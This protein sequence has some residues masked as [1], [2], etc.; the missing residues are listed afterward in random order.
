[1]NYSNFLETAVQLVSQTLLRAP[2]LV[3]LAVLAFRG[4]AAGAK[5]Q[6]ITWSLGPDLPHYRKAAVTAVIE[7]QVISACG[8]EHPWA[9]SAETFALP[10]L[11]QGAEWQQLPNCPLGRA[12]VQGTAAGNS[13]YVIGGRRNF[14]AIPDVDKLNRNA[15]GWS[16]S[17]LPD[18]NVPR[19]GA[20]AAFIGSKLYVVGGTTWNGKNNDSLGSVEVL[21]TAAANPAWTV[22][23]QIP[24]SP[25]AWSSVA[26]IN[27]KLYVFG[28]M[29][30][31]KRADGT[32]VRN[33]L[34][35]VKVYD[36]ATN[37]WQNLPPLP[38]PWHGHECAVYQNRY[39]IILGGCCYNYPEEYRE[40]KAA[41]PSNENYYNPFVIVYD[42]QEPGYR[43]LPTPL[44]YPTNNIGAALVGDTVVAIGGENIDPA[45]SNTTKYVRYGAIQVVPEPSASVML[46]AGLVI[47]S[48]VCGTKGK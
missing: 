34:D 29:D 7:G 25:R 14:A 2:A 15:Q 9:E 23:T 36:P 42:T 4:A 26:G 17:S 19:A 48:L 13:L 47:M 22:V 27:G 21:D 1:M 30:W 11:E 32:D 46:T 18:L 37:T 40:R 43:V 20:P 45:T 39:V 33:Q 24:G 6:D 38:F 8:M 41:I 44:L 16:W 12:Y 3:L 28:G 5:I 31:T 10:S 35:E